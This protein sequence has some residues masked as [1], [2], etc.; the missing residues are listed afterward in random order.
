MPTPTFPPIFT[1]API[2]TPPVTIN[3]PDVVEDD[4][5]EFVTAI[6]PE[7]RRLFPI[8]IPEPTETWVEPDAV[9]KTVPSKY[10]VPVDASIFINAEDEAVPDKEPLNVVAVIVFPRALTPERT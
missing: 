4:A 1:E 8:V 6:P 7:V 5:V 9:F 10:L 3:A 2:P